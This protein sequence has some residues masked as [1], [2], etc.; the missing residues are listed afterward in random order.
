VITARKLPAL[1]AFLTFIE[2]QREALTAADWGL[3][4][5]RAHTRI[6]TQV[7][8]V[9]SETDIVQARAM[10]ADDQCAL[11]LPPEARA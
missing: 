8:P 7:L 11:Y 6:T 9:F 4:F 1:L 10:I 2:M 3:K 5:G